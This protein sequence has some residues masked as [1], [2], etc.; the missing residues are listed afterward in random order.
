MYKEEVKCA[1]HIQY[2]K[3]YIISLAGFLCPAP[4][5]DCQCILTWIRKIDCSYRK[6]LEIPE[7]LNET[8][9]RY[10]MQYL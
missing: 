1:K 5:N 6:L 8:V 7:G 3:K 10:G 4:S 2:V 9:S